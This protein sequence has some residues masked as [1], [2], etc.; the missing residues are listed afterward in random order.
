M[1]CDAYYQDPPLE[2]S[3]FVGEDTVAILTGKPIVGF[4]DGMVF[5]GDSPPCDGVPVG[6]TYWQLQGDD[7]TIVNKG[8]PISAS[9]YASCLPLPPAKSVLVAKDI[10]AVHACWLKFD[11]GSGQARAQEVPDGYTQAVFIIVTGEFLA[12]N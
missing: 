6:G 8:G 9:I 3:D 11:T 1:Y 5:A 10:T 2:L 12:K 7:V 4:S